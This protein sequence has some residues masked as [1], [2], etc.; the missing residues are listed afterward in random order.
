MRA[1]LR[2]S[3]GDAPRQ[4]SRLS[5]P[6]EL[7][8]R[9]LPHDV[10]AEQTVLSSVLLDPR[11]LV[12]VRKLLRTEA[13]FDPR[14]ARLY[15]EL[16][17]LANEGKP[18][19][20]EVLA[21]RLKAAGAM[22]TVG[23]VAYLNEVI[24]AAPVAF[25]AAAYA[26][27]VA[28]LYRQRQLV[29]AGVR[30]LQLG[31]DDLTADRNI[32]ALS[33]E[34][35][36]V[37]RQAADDRGGVRTFGAKPVVLN[38]ADV[39]AEAITWLWPGRIALG[40]LTLVAGDPGL[41]KSFFS[42]DMAARVSLGSDWPDNV[43]TNAPRGGVVI[44]NAEDDVAKVVRPRL[45]AAGADVSRIN[46]VQAVHDEGAEYDRQLDLS[47]DL[48]ALEAAIVQ[49]PDCK[50]AII[51]PL[52]SYVGLIDAHRS[53]EVRAVVDPLAKL[54]AKYGVALLCITHL[55]KGGGGGPAIYRATGSLSFIAAA[56]AGFYVC[57]DKDRPDRRLLLPAKNNL[58]ND[59]L[60]MAYAIVNGALAWEADPVP[61]TADDAMAQA[62][63]FGDERSERREAVDWLRDVLAGGSVAVKDLQRLSNDAG[64]S[65]PAV[66][67]AKDELGVVSQRHGF[68]KGSTCTWTLPGG[69]DDR[70]API[71]SIESKPGVL[72]SMDSMNP[73]AASEVQIWSA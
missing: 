54:A 57:R 36:D 38:M 43:L 41:G 65:W 71:G 1:R 50:L 12:E 42:L 56:R 64:L 7:I 15:A 25:H 48:P 52:S 16:I 13:F 53:N 62:P 46:F 49:T 24:E 22:K 6:R 69:T 19:D 27:S 14:H 32:D 10:E 68:G 70:A 58:A 2:R 37:V 47:R 5:S 66:K 4:P 44:L 40:M 60:G 9:P 61:M 17:E 18:I 34:A 63:T 33:A 8:E 35:L 28:A 31:H 59:T 26:K 73:M 67:R 21:R 72:N 29:D 3:S 20:V 11:T 30:L 55:N 39:K 23:G 45:D 51:D